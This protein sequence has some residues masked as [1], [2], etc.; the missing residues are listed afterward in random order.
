MLKVKFVRHANSN[1]WILTDVKKSK[2][3]DKRDIPCSAY[4]GISKF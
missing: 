4:G 2:A 1:L 3:S